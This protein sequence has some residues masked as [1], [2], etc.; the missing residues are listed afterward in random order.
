M[1]HIIGTDLHWRAGSSELIEHQNMAQRS[2]SVY[3]EVFTFSMVMN[4]LYL[5]EKFPE[6]HQEEHDDGEEEDGYRQ[7]QARSSSSQGH[8]L[9]H[10][11]RGV[12]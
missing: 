4:S 9:L 7:G 12:T 8:L 11:V 1:E 5:W 2:K 10:V 3:R 6:G